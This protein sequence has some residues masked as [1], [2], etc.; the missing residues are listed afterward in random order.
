MASLGTPKVYTTTGFGPRKNKNIAGVDHFLVY[1]QTAV[2]GLQRKDLS[3]L[4][5]AIPPQKTKAGIVPFGRLRGGLL[6]P[7]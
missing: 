4:I 2:K 1:M 7:I 6:M 3:H 5:P